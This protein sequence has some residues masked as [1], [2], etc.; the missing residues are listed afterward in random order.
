MVGSFRR[1]QTR[2]FGVNVG[3]SYTG[4]AGTERRW[5]PNKNGIAAIITGHTGSKQ[6]S[7]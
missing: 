3:K 4:T 7:S 6:G 2:E 1:R 5:K